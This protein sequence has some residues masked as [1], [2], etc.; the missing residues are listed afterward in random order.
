MNYDEATVIFSYDDDGA[1]TRKQLNSSYWPEITE[2]F[3]EFLRGVGFV[4][5]TQD[6]V[7]HFTQKNQEWVDAITGECVGCRSVGHTSEGQSGETEVRV[8]ADY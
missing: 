7:D 5:S 8:S 4:F 2:A 6:F 3:I 1:T